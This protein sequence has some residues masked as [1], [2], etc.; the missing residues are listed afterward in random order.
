M[1]L[2]LT[3]SDGHQL[4]AYVATPTGSPRGAIVVIQEIFGV[5]THIRAVADG[6]ANDGYLAIAPSLFDRVERD[7]KLDYTPDAIQRGR[8][9]KV[10]ITTEWM[11]RD[12]AA[13]IA[14]VAHA[15]KVGIVGYCWGGLQAWR[16]ACELEGL[17][18]AVPYYGG[19]I[20]T[21]AEIARRPRVPVLAHFSD[22]DKFIPLDGVEAFRRAHPD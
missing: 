11:A 22:R 20:T 6:W 7:V 12:V 8:E 9:L 2:Q 18:A 3:A 21:E 1:D 16:A 17:S 4:A 13:A 5:N 15:G 10:K 19:G 14:H